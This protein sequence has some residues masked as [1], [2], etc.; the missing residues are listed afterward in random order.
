M[1]TYHVLGRGPFRRRGERHPE[2]SRGYSGRRFE[3]RKHENDVAFAANGGDGRLEFP[4]SRIDAV[5]CAG[6]SPTARR[7]AQPGADHTRDVEA[8]LSELDRS[9]LANRFGA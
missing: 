5:R 3:R 6:R 8:G 1:G 9:V 2:R 7:R 4:I